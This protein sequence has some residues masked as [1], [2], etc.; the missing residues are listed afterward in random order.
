MLVE[1]SRDILSLG[2]LAWQFEQ[3]YFRSLL[4]M[5]TP[6]SSSNSNLAGKSS[7][8]KLDEVTKLVNILSKD[9]TSNCLSS[10]QRDTYLEELKIYGRDPSY[11]D[12]IYTNEGIKTLAG[13][14]FNSSSKTT[15]RNALKCLANTML[16][17][18]ETRQM[19]VDLNLEDKFYDKMKDGNMEDEFLMSR[20]LFLTTY[21]TNIDLEKL[22]D[23]YHIA[24]AICLNIG[25]H[26]RK[27]LSEKEQNSTDLF[28][29]MALA[30]TLKLIF[31]L[32]HFCPQRKTAFASVLKDLI[33]LF[34][35]CPV[36][37]TSPLE[38][39]ISLVI[40][41]IISLDFNE[42]TS[43]LFFPPS[44][45]KIVATRCVKLLDVSIIKYTDEDLEQN[46]TPLVI[47]LQ[48]V[49]NL[50]PQAVQTYLRQS[51]LPS[52]EDRQQVLGRA[53]ST[54]S[55]LLCLLSNP[56]TPQLRESISNLL[57]E[58][59]G[60]DASKFVQ[61]VG[62]GFASGFLCNHNISVP[63]GILEPCEITEDDTEQNLSNKI[64]PVTGQLLEKEEKL[65][66]ADMTEEEKEREAEKLFVLFERLK[67][68]GVLSVKNP[69][70]MYQNT[71]KF[72]ELKDETD[73]E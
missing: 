72:E 22:N 50:A 28:E 52:I 8:A 39:P 69:L 15:S 30:E 24:D 58:L 65:D 63:E 61:N 25:R 13:H 6:V 14:A 43:T 60:K 3:L 68:N 54:P 49:N 55:R 34:I 47:L 1:R 67:K 44:A 12:P 23:Q 31:N 48:K 20:I 2:Q 16:L 40:N 7:L 46:A 29:E 4:I 53:D 19:F 57:F 45:P 32:N 42:E 35:E 56:M 59:S 51:L 5:S 37:E 62:Y 17:R 33:T 18:A 70:E 66:L 73:P 26:A 21:G 71:G 64:N 10:H 36:Q 27:I 41:A 38:P 9:L 11:S